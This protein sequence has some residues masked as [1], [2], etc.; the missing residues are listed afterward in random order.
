MTD[1][2][3]EGRD[4]EL[5]LRDARDQ[6][7]AR[8]HDLDQDL[9]AILITT[10]RPSRIPLLDAMDADGLRAVTLEILDWVDE[11]RNFP[12][13]DEIFKDLLLRSHVALGTAPDAIAALAD[14]TPPDEP[15]C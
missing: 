2:T 13:A 14:D 9:T 11:C 8:L 12:E 7:H 10:D 5:E 1:Q 4:R 15:P 6:M 3:P